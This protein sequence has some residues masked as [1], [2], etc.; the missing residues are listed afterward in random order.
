[1]RGGR[2][3]CQRTFPK[4]ATIKASA[5]EAASTEIS[6]VKHAFRQDGFGEE[7]ALN[8]RSLEVYVDQ[9]RAEVRVQHQRRK[10]PGLLH[11]ESISGDA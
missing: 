10:L 8:R 4:G 11:V 7:M 2:S 5:V 9:G 1:M 6:L 3:G